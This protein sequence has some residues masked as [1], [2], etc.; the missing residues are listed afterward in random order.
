MS[1]QTQLSCQVRNHG[2]NKQKIWKCKKHRWLL[3]NSWCNPPHIIVEEKPGKTAVA[4]HFRHQRWIPPY[5]MQ[6]P[7]ADQL[8]A[9]ISLVHCLLA[10]NRERR[11]F[12]DSSRDIITTNQLNIMKTKRQTFDT[13]VHENGLIVQYRISSLLSQKQNRSFFFG[14]K[15]SDITWEECPVYEFKQ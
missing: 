9:G 2:W 7:A 11:Q 12:E 5:L 6:L 8:L 15:S 13:R 14:W 10:T 4:C 3:S 1:L